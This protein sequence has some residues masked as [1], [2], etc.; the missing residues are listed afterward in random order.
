MA[1]TNAMNLFGPSILATPVGE[2]NETGHLT[3][4]HYGSGYRNFYGLEWSYPGLMPNPWNNFDTPQWEL[5]NSPYTS[6]PHLRK[7]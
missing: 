5:F 4:L 6:G 1:V 7:Q 3:P 2:Y